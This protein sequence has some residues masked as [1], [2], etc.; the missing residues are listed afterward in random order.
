M[1][2]PRPIAL[3]DEEAL[4][5]SYDVGQLTGHGATLGTVAYMS[6]EQALG[7][8]LDPRTDLFSLGVVIYEALTGKPAFMG[9]TSA[10]IFDQILNRAPTSPVQLN[11]RVSPELEG[12]V[13]KL[14]EK[15]AGL[16]YQHASE[17]HADLKRMR[18]DTDSAPP[19]A[20]SVPGG[21]SAMECAEGERHGRPRCPRA[22]GH[23][24]VGE[25]LR[26]PGT[27]WD[28]RAGTDD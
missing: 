14:L 23:G 3:N 2:W 12:V 4:T 7:K 21:R 16:R 24:V 19:A 26:R 11:P 1:A 13:N 17:L 28:E 27:G 5:V 6:P 8:E 22:R 25:E 15:D 9:A 18:R 20:R 10:A